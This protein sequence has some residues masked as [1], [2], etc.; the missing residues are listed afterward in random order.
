[1]PKEQRDYTHI[2]HKAE[3]EALATLDTPIKAVQSVNL[4]A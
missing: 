4:T 2:S 1:M 3:R